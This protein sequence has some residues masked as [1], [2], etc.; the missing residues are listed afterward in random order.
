MSSTSLRSALSYRV[1]LCDSSRQSTSEPPESVLQGMPSRP[2]SEPSLE[3]IIQEIHIFENQ[4]HHGVYNTSRP[5]YD[6]E[7]PMISDMNFEINGIYSR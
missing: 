4:I 2:A 1:N 5:L 6:R 3:S 7:S